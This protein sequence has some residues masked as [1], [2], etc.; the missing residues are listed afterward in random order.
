MWILEIKMSYFLKKPNLRRKT[1]QNLFY[2]YV[3]YSKVIKFESSNQ[4]LC[5]DQ[6]GIFIIY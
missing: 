6:R 5:Q 4:I 1:N 3:K 2:F